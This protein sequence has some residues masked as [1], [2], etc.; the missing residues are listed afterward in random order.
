M[1]FTGGEILA[2][3]FALERRIEELKSNIS[4][5][6]GEEAAEDCKVLLAAAQSALAKIQ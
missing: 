5:W 6:A 1:K 3:Q 2:I 4:D